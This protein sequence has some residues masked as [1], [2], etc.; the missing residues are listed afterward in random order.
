MKL[1]ASII[2]IIAVV[3]LIVAIVLAIS[4]QMLVAAANGWLDL[5]LTLLVLSIA[6]VVVKPFQGEA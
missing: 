5:S 1:L 2:G 3:C 6:L 4:N